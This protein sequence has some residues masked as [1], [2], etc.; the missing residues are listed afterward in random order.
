MGR[1]SQRKGRSGELEL[2]KILNEH[3]ISAEPG[4]AV[5]FGKTPD[6]TGVPGIH[7]EVK[8]NEHLNVLEALSQAIEDSRKFSDGIPALFHRKNRSP[9]L[10][11]MTFEDWIQLYTEWSGSHER[12]S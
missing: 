3:G 8:R 10:V 1:K 5:S 7:C 2:V 4:Q 12:V 9:W 6:V 11:T